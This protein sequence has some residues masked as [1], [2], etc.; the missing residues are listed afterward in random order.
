MAKVER[1]EDLE[2]WK[3]ARELVKEIYLI[4]QKKPLSTDFETRSQLKSAGI[5]TMNNIAE[6]FSRFHTK[7]FIRFL[8]FSQSSAGEVKSMFYVL[9]DVEYV[10]K[11]KA[12]ELH[13]MVD[14]TK[15]LTLGL[16]KYLAKSNK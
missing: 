13:Q 4:C 8:D 1:F 14:K 6:G 11:Q 3:A 2:C 15:N 12:I 5:S 7:E 16:I 9:E 10:T